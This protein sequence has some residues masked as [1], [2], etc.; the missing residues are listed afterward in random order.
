M[1]TDYV[2]MAVMNWWRVGDI[3]DALFEDSLTKQDIVN[4]QADRVF[5]KKS[6]SLK[7]KKYRVYEDVLE[8]MEDSILNDPI[9]RQLGAVDTY[10]LRYYG[11]KVKDWRLGPRAT[12]EFLESKVIHY[13]KAK[14]VKPSRGMVVLIQ[15][16]KENSPK[17]ETTTESAGKVAKADQ[18]QGK[19]AKS[20]FPQI[21]SWSQLT[22]C[23]LKDYRMEVSFAGETF[24]EEQ[25]KAII[26]KH[27]YLLLFHIVARGKLFDNNS[28]S[29]GVFKKEYVKRLKDCLKSGFK[30]NEDPLP[31]NR[32]AK[33]YEIKFKCKSDIPEGTFLPEDATPS[34]VPRKIKNTRR[35]IEEQF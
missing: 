5:N 4:C 23:I 27:L 14:G 19:P 10:T 31:Y 2:K 7:H 24:S 33:A 17:Q 16:F 26:P 15:A 21:D 32:N 30:I 22:L 25:L 12:L 35:S 3:V 6:R 29:N 13:M 20:G 28:F 11:E 34:G 8:I 1:C 18:P 9:F